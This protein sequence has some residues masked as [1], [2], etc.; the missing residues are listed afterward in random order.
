[1]AFRWIAFALLALVLG[2][3]SAALAQGAGDDQYEDPFGDEQ[4]EEQPAPE[5]PAP[6]EPEEA[7]A[8]APEAAGEPA[9]QPAQSTPSP[10]EGGGGQLPYTGA[11]TGLLALAGALL[12]ASGLAL[13][14]R[15]S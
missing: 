8:P 9:A 6:E 5:E 4:S 12:L 3:P 15:W 1:M 13:R 14:R 11:E 2:F 7:P 10:A